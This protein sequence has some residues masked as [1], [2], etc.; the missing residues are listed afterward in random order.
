M[1]MCPFLGRYVCIE[2]KIKNRKELCLIHVAV[3]PPHEHTST[4]ANTSTHEH[5]H[6]RAHAHTHTHTHAQHA[7]AQACCFH[8]GCSS[9][10]AQGAA[11]RL[12]SYSFGT[13]RAYT[14]PVVS[15]MVHPAGLSFVQQRK[16]VLAKT[17]GEP[18]EDIAK[19]VVNL[20][21]QRPTVRT[22]SNVVRSFSSR[23]G[24]VKTKYKN[25]G[26]Y[27]W[28]IT[29]EV[30]SFLIQ[31]LR[32]LRRTWPCT[33]TT[34]QQ[35]LAQQKRVKVSCSAIR[36]VLRDHGYKWLP[37]RQKV[38][39]SKEVMKMRLKFA[40]QIDSK[41]K[42]RLEKALALC[43]DGVI[44]S[45][46]PENATD[47]LNFVRHGNDHELRNADSPQPGAFGK[48]RLPQASPIGARHTP[49]QWLCQQGLRSDSIPLSRQRSG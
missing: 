25:C 48:G 8:V 24:R 18:W 15:E 29:E 37:K 33:S 14:M 3:M 2:V 27:A 10:W 44:L 43:M 12:A 30:E 39:Y 41:S 46:A 49:L 40:G 9:L 31:R 23:A 34:L 7:C 32:V 35:E 16:V 1:C 26:R 45:K 4:Q 13:L 17:K 6:A 42:A 47:R 38:K 5:A 21:D 28:K 22:C 20:R 11:C 19:S 36:K